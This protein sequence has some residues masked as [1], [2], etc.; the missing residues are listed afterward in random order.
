MKTLGKSRELPC[1]DACNGNGG[2]GAERKTPA[3]LHISAPGAEALVR[4]VIPTCGPVSV[5]M[6]QTRVG[7]HTEIVS[8]TVTPD[9]HQIRG[10]ALECLDI[11]SE[12]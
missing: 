7:G 8:E 4:G 12:D 6:S 3:T 10:L 9:R 11:G 2:C 5:I 1:I